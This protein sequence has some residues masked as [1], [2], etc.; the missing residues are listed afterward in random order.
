[1][2]G[3]NF[4]LLI[5]KCCRYLAICPEG[6]YQAEGEFGEFEANKYGNEESS[7]CE[8]EVSPSGRARKFSE[9]KTDGRFMSDPDTNQCVFKSAISSQEFILIYQTSRLR[10]ATLCTWNTALD[11]GNF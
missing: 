10:T 6:A 11:C 7:G 5:E 2:H 9:K 8:I 3:L 1:M 4:H